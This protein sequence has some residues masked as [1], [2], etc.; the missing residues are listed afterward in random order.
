MWYYAELQSLRMQ[1]CLTVT[2]VGA[3]LLLGGCLKAPSPAKAVASKTKAYMPPA[4]PDM[5][6]ADA[7]HTMSQLGAQVIRNEEDTVRSVVLTDLPVSD[8]AL[9]PLKDLPDLEVLSLSGTRV[10]NNGMMHLRGLDRLSYL[11]MNNTEV[12]DQG[13]LTLADSVALRYISLDNTNVTSN[14]V[15]EFRK[16]SPGTVVHFSPQKASGEKYFTPMSSPAD[17]A[18]SA[19]MVGVDSP[20][21][22]WVKQVWLLKMAGSLLSQPTWK[23]RIRL[24]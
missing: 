24:W 4:S 11:F 7:A 15:E 18:L 22:R 10:T 17:I 9:V 2:A 14:A 8:S 21:N 1:V 19:K 23:T 16:L 5:L 12:T 3:T 13:L 20:P 6:S